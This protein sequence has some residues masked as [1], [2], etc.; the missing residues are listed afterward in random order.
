MLVTAPLRRP[1]IARLW[2]GLA[3]AALGDEVFALT[4]TWIAVGIAGPTASLIPALQSAALLATAVF[5]GLIVDRRDPA[6]TL[7]AAA[8]V[9]ATNAALLVAALWVAGPTLPVLAAAAVVMTATRAFTEPSVQMVLPR[10]AEGREMI[11]ASTALFDSTLR[12]ARVTAPL[13]VGGA[14]ALFAPM[15]LLV[16]A[17]AGQLGLAAAARR[18]P[19]GPPD[20]T[21]SGAGPDPG[22]ALLGGLRAARRHPAF[23]RSLLVGT[24]L[25]GTWW[26]GI[27]FG[28]ALL[29][30]EERLGGVGGDA[31]LGTYALLMAAYGCGNLVA[32]LIVGSRP[33][34][35]PV[36]VSYLGTLVNGLGIAVIGAVPLLME[37]P[38]V[39]PTMLVACFVCAS[40][41]P[42]RDLAIILAVQTGFA[43]SDIGRLVRLRMV[44]IHLGIL[45]GML[46]AGPLYALFDTAHVIVGCGLLTGLATLA[47]MMRPIEEVTP[48]RG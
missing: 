8:L 29:V 18:L 20:T 44:S 28:L 21:G 43:G 12:F 45:P 30:H 1:A 39:V 42:V 36:L 25:N 38:A 37:G 13:V 9:R 24:V 14:Q 27:P 23:A 34:H 17:V 46:L 15:W 4:L 10:L 40:G 26:A 35:R 33:M 11:R 31:D 48:V 47:G 3:G 6:R 16:A 19:P 41:G 5:G 2:G 32:T 7:R 22:G